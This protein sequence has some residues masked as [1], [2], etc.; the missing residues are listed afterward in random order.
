MR[1]RS[2][3]ILVGIGIIVAALGTMYAVA[4]TRS[5]A[6]LREAYA[7]LEKDD[8]PMRAADV[9]PEKVPDDQNG[10]VLY[11]KAAAMLKA[12]P[13]QEKN[14]LKHLGTLAGAPFKKTDDPDRLARK[15]Q[16]VEE[17]KQLMGREV[18]TQAISVVEEGTRRPACQF[19]DRDAPRGLSLESPAMEDL[20]D[21][22]RVVGTRAHLEAEAGRSEKAWGMIPTLLRFADGPRNEPSVGSQF[23]RTG[24]TNYS[25]AAIQTLCNTA[26]PSGENYR[27]TEG[28]LASLDNV[29]P[30]VRA[31]DRERLLLGEWL[32]SLPDDELFEALRKNPWTGEDVN[33][34]L[35]YRLTFRFLTFKPRF[36]ADHAAYL[37]IMSKS[38]QLLQSAYVPRESQE[39]KEIEALTGHNF[40][41][42]RLAPFIWGIQWAYYRMTASVRLTRAGL[43]LMQY[44]QTHGTWPPSLDALG[45][46]DLTDPFIRQPLHYRPQGEGFLVYSVG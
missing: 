24:M 9:T 22:I 2:R 15:K 17:L 18:V 7:A 1:K 46:N 30:L 25:C 20:R 13:D 42:D 38:T 37:Q 33:P 3:R 34:R 10:A 29:E 36:N 16:E 26:P 11:R 27:E 41:T 12:Q 31:M 35:G 23:S 28:L 39:Y 21:L 5:T 40:V 4:L 45:L 6:R 14:L 43:A 32:F 8:R 44:K 19:F